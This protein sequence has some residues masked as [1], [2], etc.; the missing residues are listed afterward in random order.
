MTPPSYRAAFLTGHSVPGCTGLSREQREFQ[1][2]SAVPA[3]HWLPWNF[4]YH[5]THPFPEPVP[6]LSASVN[7]L[8]H[9]LGSR[10]EGFRRRHRDAVMERLSPWPVVI[11]LAGSCGLELLANLELP[12]ELLGRLHVFAYGPVSRRLP[13][14]ATCRLVQGQRDWLSRFYHRR[15]DHRI[16]CP[17][18]GYLTAPETLPLF[19]AFCHDVL[20]GGGA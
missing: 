9:Y 2:R 15:V 3:S 1:R 4:P 17:H 5:E 12:K 16:D 19:D 18:M 13:G 8:R 14:A 11:L 20:K 7:N 6:L 10:R